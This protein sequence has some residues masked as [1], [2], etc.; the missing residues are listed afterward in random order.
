MDR[1]VVIEDVAHV[2]DIET[3]RSHVAC[4][5]EGDG[6]VAE[7]VERGR[8]LMLIEVAIL[9]GKG[10]LK[11]SGKLGEVMQESAQAALSYIRT[12]EELMGLDKDFYQ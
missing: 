2:G 7:G 3:A 1:H 5:K 4:G 9:P 11:I 6:A 8:T 12:R 10:N